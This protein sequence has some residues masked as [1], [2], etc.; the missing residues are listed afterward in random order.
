MPKLS[1]LGTYGL[2]R[3]FYG[4]SALEVV[5]LSSLKKF[6]TQGLNAA[7]Q[8]CGNLREVYLT[9]LSSAGTALQNG[10]TNTF[11]GC[12]SLE[13]VH[14]EKAPAVPTL[15][16]V[17]AFSNTNAYYQILVPEALYSAWVSATNWSN[18]AIS[19]HIVGVPQSLS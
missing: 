8:N 3:A 6:T 19:G 4:C 16:N 17:N 18:S 1:A 10:F 12:S 5:N 7:F 11:N 15:A 13:Y 2:T 14:F 9:N